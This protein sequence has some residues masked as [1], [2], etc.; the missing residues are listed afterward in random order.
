M[1]NIQLKLTVEE[2]NTIL[3]SLGQQPYIKVA[4]LIRKIQ[5]QGAS[6]MSKHTPAE[7]VEKQPAEKQK[8]VKNSVPVRNG[9]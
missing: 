9:N 8:E 5:E 2:A 4:D 6:Q 7:F 1:E 3:A